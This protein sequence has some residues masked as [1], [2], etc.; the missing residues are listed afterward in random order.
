MEEIILFRVRVP[1][2]LDGVELAAWHKQHCKRG[3]RKLINDG[4]TLMSGRG[5]LL[6]GIYQQHPGNSIWTTSGSLPTLRL[7]PNP[8]MAGERISVLSDQP[9]SPDAHLQLCSPM[10]AI[11]GECS[12]SE[13]MGEGISAPVH[14]GIYLLRITEGTATA[15][16]CLLVSRQ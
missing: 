13:L 3:S 2:S 11:I 12:P 16:T 4:H 14:P 8:A 5:E 10:G 7:Y 15:S 6:A 9:I 1:G